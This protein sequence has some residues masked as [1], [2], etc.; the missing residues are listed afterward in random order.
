MREVVQHHLVTFEDVKGKTQNRLKF[1]VELTAEDAR[2]VI[3]KHIDVSVEST[4]FL[5]SLKEFEHLQTFLF[6]LNPTD[7]EIVNER[8]SDDL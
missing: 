8:S 2:I 4:E 7:V 3:T 6:H 5:L 1:L